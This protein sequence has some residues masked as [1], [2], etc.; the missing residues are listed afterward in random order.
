MVKHCGGRYRPAG[1]NDDLEARKKKAYRCFDLFFRN[2]QDIV[3]QSSARWG[4]L[5]SPGFRDLS[6]S[7]MVSGGEISTCRPARSDKSPIVG[8]LRLSAE[9]LDL[10]ID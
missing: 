1:F 10:G 5:A 4:T 7:A 6:P 3:H 9:H 2:Q 8:D